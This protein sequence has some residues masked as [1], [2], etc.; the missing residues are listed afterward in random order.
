MG[1]AGATGYTGVELIRLLAQ[2]P[3]AEVV[4]AGAETTR[5]SPWPGSTPTCGGVWNWSDREASPEALAGC[6]VVFT[7]LPHGV[8]MALARRYSRR[9]G[10]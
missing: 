1:I 7:A 10:G 8:T 9:A 6:D 3:E 5:G 4:V 2:H